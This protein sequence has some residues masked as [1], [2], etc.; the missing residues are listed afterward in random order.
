[1][2]T[3]KNNKLRTIFQIGIKSNTDFINND[4]EVKE[5]SFFNFFSFK[6]DDNT[7]SINENQKEEKMIVSYNELIDKNDLNAINDLIKNNS[8][9][10]PENI[11]KIFFSTPYSIYLSYHLGYS[12]AKKLLSEDNFSKLYSDNL[13]SD[14]I[15]IMGNKYL[16]IL[17]A[18]NNYM[19]ENKQSL[20]DNWLYLLNNYPIGNLISFD[21]SIVKCSEIF[22]YDFILKLPE[23]DRKN[24]ITT[25][26]K[27][28]INNSLIWKEL[29][30]TFLAAYQ[31]EA[32][33]LITNNHLIELKLLDNIPENIKPL[34]F[35]INKISNKILNDESIESN[36]K[37]NIRNIVE[38]KVNNILNQYL[39]ID[40]EYRD[41]IQS[42]QNKNATELLI[43]S[44]Y[45]IHNVIL[46]IDL[47]INKEKIS[48][49][50][51]QN[52]HTKKL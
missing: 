41:S 2:T 13:Q 24:I 42:S 30:K 38:N 33:D 52:R 50:S 34:I 37:D 45:N 44:I 46:S 51:V 8:L 21:Y 14:F 4:N 17:E 16:Q 26:D 7:T 49:L 28:D 40:K 39:D 18:V 11:H 22:L 36:I 47:D 29:K 6:K 12:E 48:T 25:I 35:D 3:L 20:F 27:L 43:D 31:L 9:L 32:F 5:S 1:M 10:Y 23:E 15:D 19:K